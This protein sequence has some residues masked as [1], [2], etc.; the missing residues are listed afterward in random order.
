MSLEQRAAA[1]FGAVQANDFDA[2]IATFDDNLGKALTARKFKEVWQ[3][4]ERQHGAFLGYEAPVR[5]PKTKPDTVLVGLNFERG[6]MVARVVFRPDQRIGGLAFEQ[7]WTAPAYADPRRF[8]ERDLVVGAPGW[9]LPATLTVPK[10]A[11]G[12]PAV[13][14]VHGSGPKDRDETIGP[15]KTFKDLAWGLASRG[16]AVLRYD[17]RTLAHRSK[18]EPVPDDFTVDAE[19]IADAL[20]ALK[21]LGQEPEVAED[22]VY[23]LGHGLGGQLAPRIAQRAPECKGLIILAGSARTMHEK[24]REQADYLASLSTAPSP[25]QKAHLEFMRAEAKRL[26]SLYSSGG[27]DAGMILGTPRGY[28]LDLRDYDGP[29]QAAELEKPVLVLQGG[30]DYQVTDRDFELW[31]KALGSQAQANLIRFEALDH[32]FMRGEG[33]SQPSD[34]QRP[35]HVDAEVLDT[36]ARFIQP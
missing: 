7:A 2:A 31:Q 24:I 33:K 5:E 36:I 15:N 17:K 11:Q 8:A 14:L 1:L 28:W 10:S 29:A 20:T 16:I 3:Q 9:Q 23:V 21:A 27:S 19:I 22:Q 4:A 26:E 32:L 25:A 34:Y 30:R 35:G 18:L 12:V 13:L 6:K